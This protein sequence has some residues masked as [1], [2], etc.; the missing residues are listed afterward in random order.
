MT[1]GRNINDIYTL[2]GRRFL[3]EGRV[4]MTDDHKRKILQVSIDAVSES[5]SGL[6]ACAVGKGHSL[7]TF[8]VVT[9]SVMMGMY[10]V[11]FIAGSEI[12]HILVTIYCYVLTSAPQIKKVDTVRSPVPTERSFIKHMETSKSDMVTGKIHISLLKRFWVIEI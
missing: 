1:A 6:Y 4:S 9:L 5:D 2:K 7:E 12:F 11:A 8:A 3:H 10:A